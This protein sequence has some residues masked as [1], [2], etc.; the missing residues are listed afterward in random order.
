MR[1][2]R[3]L[4]K[5]R[6]DKAIKNSATESD[7]TVELV[8]NKK[9]TIFEKV[10]GN[11]EKRND[12]GLVHENSTGSGRRQNDAAASV[13]FDVSKS[14]KSCSDQLEIGLTSCVL[15]KRTRD[16]WKAETKFG[17][18]RD[19]SVATGME[20]EPI[21]GSVKETPT[22]TAKT[23]LNVPTFVKLAPDGQAVS[24]NNTECSPESHSR[25]DDVGSR[26]VLC[27]MEQR[28]SGDE[29]TSV[30]DSKSSSR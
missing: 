15:V 20:K 27:T 4:A 11:S 16:G 8:H 26:D 25:T 9:S 28:H 23:I 7:K 10:P 13:D 12:N 29:T 5:Q 1:K 21:V 22:R 2:N 14:A 3:S 17:R 6:V 19:G 18:S 30:D 24:P